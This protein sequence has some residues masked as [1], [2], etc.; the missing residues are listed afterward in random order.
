MTTKKD[1][2][3][4]LDKLEKRFTEMEKDI[5]CY[6]IKYAEKSDPEITE[7]GK[8]YALK[9]CT[10]WLKGHISFRTD[11]G[12][13]KSVS[14]IED[15]TQKPLFVYEIKPGGEYSP[16]HT[17]DDIEFRNKVALRKIGDTGGD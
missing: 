16:I 9:N 2:E 12:Q 3:E 7:E 8:R 6:W 11:C 17:L 13:L 1:L 14:L 4:K 5:V 10:K 15:G